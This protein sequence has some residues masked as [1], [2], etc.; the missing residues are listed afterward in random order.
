MPRAV[1]VFP[2]LLLLAVPAMPAAA[3]TIR[4]GTTTAHPGEIVTVEVWYEAGGGSVGFDFVGRFEPA[5]E[6]VAFRQGGYPDTLC[7]VIASRNELRII[8][9]TLDLSVLPDHRACSVDLRV[10]PSASPGWHGLVFG[11]AEPVFHFSDP[12][13]QPLPGDLH[14]GGVYV[15]DPDRAN[16]CTLVRQDMPDPDFVPEHAPV[17]ACLRSA[18][19]P[20][21]RCGI[22]IPGMFELW[23]EFPPTPDPSK[24]QQVTWT[25][26]PLRDGL[27]ELAVDSWSEHGGLWTKPVY[28]PKNP[29][30]LQPQTLSTQF[31]VEGTKPLEALQV[32]I[33][34]DG[35]FWQFEQQWSGQPEE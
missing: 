9:G 7:N 12:D 35:Q 26:I 24:W 10:D 5:L 4:F 27:P 28:F 1:P 6:I 18:D 31:K 11:P 2:F 20:L 19:F 17:C 14:G 3:Q 13:A 22:R 8:G 30:P 32:G 25:L 15:L 29:T 16:A 34:V 21:H 33:K 23:R